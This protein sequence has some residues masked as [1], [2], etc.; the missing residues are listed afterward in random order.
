MFVG[1]AVVAL[2]VGLILVILIVRPVRAAF[3]TITAHLGVI[4]TGDF[5]KD[6]PA[7]YL[8]GKDEMGQIARAVDAMQKAI[9]SI[10]LGVSGESSNLKSTVEFS[11]RVITE[12][13]T[14]I[15]EISA[16]TQELSAG[17]EETAA[18]MEEMNA[19]SMEI[20]KAV[21]SIAERAQEGALASGSIRKRAE[22]LRENAAL[23]LKSAQAIRESMDS[24]LKE[25][26]VQ[27][28]AIEQIGVLSDA[29]LQ[30]SS[31][32]NLL[33]LNA[34]IEAARAGEAGK[35]FAVV[36]DEIR[37]LAED[38]QN[39]V[40][41][42]RDIVRTIVQSV[43]NLSAASGDV[44]EF[45]SGQVEKDYEQMART[46]EQYFNDAGYIDGLVG[47]FSATSQQLAASIQNMLK[48][49]NEV[50]LAA[51]EGAEGTTNIA[52]MAGKIAEESSEVV[53]Q[54]NL[55]DTSSRKLSDI[56]G[57]FKLQ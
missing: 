8:K 54:V 57:Q 13:N 33:A 15:E 16:T 3:K 7:G 41:Q 32:T 4:S 28:M 49:I 37:K 46:G 9:H 14:Q 17:M 30:V 35:G 27:A 23:S 19:T 53:H 25:A 26:I 31:Q 22:E 55:V 40:N 44:L 5:S 51:N 34:T 21:E 48:A 10:A 18:S 47:D 2:A 42:M 12:L 50:T 29:I 39:A 56:V 38:S 24:R 45:L 11:G 20:E 52:Q 36:A 1:I 6:V 43:E